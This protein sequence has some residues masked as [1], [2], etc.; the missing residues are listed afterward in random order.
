ML[1]CLQ[2]SHLEPKTQEGPFVTIAEHDV[3]VIALSVE[4]EPK[5]YSNP[6]MGKIWS[7][8]QDLWTT[9]GLELSAKMFYL[10]RQGGGKS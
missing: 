1:C 6:L 3:T 10:W 2:F 8:L 9:Q 7:T 5:Y 4:P